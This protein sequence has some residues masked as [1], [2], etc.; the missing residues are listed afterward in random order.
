MSDRIDTHSQNLS[1]QQDPSLCPAWCAGEHLRT[2]LTDGWHHDGSSVS[3]ELV[4]RGA[5]GAGQV[6]VHSS[7]YVSLDGN[8]HPPIV[9]MQDESRTLALLTSGEARDLAKA[10]TD[11]ADQVVLALQEE[12]VTRQV[13]A[14]TD[15]Q[16]RVVQLILQAHARGLWAPGELSDALDSLNLTGAADEAERRLATRG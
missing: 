2:M 4:D 11:V 5:D 15:E 13:G 3:I 10:L 14:L 8:V 7:Q 6:F 1:P 16:R 9:E 12:I